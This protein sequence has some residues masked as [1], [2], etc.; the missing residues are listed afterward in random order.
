MEDK[1]ISCI[2]LLDSECTISLLEASASQLKPFLHNRRAE[3]LE[4]MDSVSQ[5]CEI[6]PINWVANSP[7]PAD[8]LTRGTAKLND[9]SLDTTWQHGPKFLSLPRER[10]PVTRDC[11]SRIEKFLKMSC[12]RLMHT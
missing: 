6:E 5:I 4:N 12:A 9:I 10:W 3:I 8:I 1:P 7:N 2:I 11:I